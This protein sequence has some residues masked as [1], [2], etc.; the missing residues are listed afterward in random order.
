MM[1]SRLKILVP[2]WVCEFQLETNLFLK[3]DLFSSERVTLFL[4]NARATEFR[5]EG[6]V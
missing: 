5:V 2:S 4:S 1:T 6:A 3:M